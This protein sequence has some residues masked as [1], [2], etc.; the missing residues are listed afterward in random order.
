MQFALTNALNRMNAFGFSSF[1]F[2]FSGLNSSVMQD[3]FRTD[4]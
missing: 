1:D 4:E 2:S 3:V